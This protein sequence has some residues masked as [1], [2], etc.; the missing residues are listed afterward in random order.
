PL[1]AERRVRSVLCALQDSTVPLRFVPDVFG[2]QL[3]N[4]KVNIVAGLPV[5]DLFPS[6]MVGMNRVLKAVEDRVL[7][8]IILLLLSPLLL[9]L[10]LGVKLSSPGPVIFRQ[11]RHGW[12]GKP[13]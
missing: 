11:R 12:D 6:P 7:V 5:I 13:F 4:H 8:L 3:L 10:V 9:I 1:R 2:A